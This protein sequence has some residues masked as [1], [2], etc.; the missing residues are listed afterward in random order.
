M[1][2]ERHNPG[3]IVKPDIGHEKYLAVNGILKTAKA[4]GEV[5]DTPSGEVFKPKTKSHR[6]YKRV[7]QGRTPQC[8]AFGTLTYLYAAHP[9]NKALIH[10]VDNKTALLSGQELY[11]RIREWDRAH[12]NDFPEGATCTAAFETAKD[13]GW[14]ER[15]EWMYTIRNMQEAILIAPLEAGIYWYD[16]MF[17]RDEENIVKVPR[18]WDTTD[19]GHFGTLG[20]Y[21]A[22]R[23]IW[24]WRQTWG[25]GDYGIP[26]DLMFRL[27]KEEGE[28]AIVTEIDVTP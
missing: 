27:L 17:E 9:Y 7:D 20:A 19:A 28:V 2:M 18:S 8:T 26:G 1:I 3:L 5:P 6:Q 22:K 10:G 14:I 11:D 24:W 21:D 15:Y 13:L 25:D 4:L 16:S 12:G 23:D